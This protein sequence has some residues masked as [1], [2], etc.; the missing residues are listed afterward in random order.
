MVLGVDW[1]L[2]ALVP[3]AVSSGLLGMFAAVALAVAAAVVVEGAVIL[4]GAVIVVAQFPTEHTRAGWLE[5]NNF[6]GIGHGK[7][8]T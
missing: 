1:A 4:A 5:L 3:Q 8:T 6:Q 2:Y 7:G